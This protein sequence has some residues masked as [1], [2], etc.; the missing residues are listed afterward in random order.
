MAFN[1]Y[2]RTA[3]REPA[4]VAAGDSSDPYAAYLSWV[5]QGRPSM[6][7]PAARPE[8]GTVF[9]MD[10]I[11]VQELAGTP[12]IEAPPSTWKRLTSALRRIAS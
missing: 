2:R 9:V 7:G 11:Q 4:P 10:H 8:P 3:P 6:T 12:V 5:A 1:H